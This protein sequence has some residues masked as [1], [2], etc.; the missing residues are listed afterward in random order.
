MTWAEGEPRATG[1]RPA[2]RTNQGLSK[3]ILCSSTNAIRR[4][5]RPGVYAGLGVHVRPKGA[6]VRT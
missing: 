5:V 6:C 1:K 4:H 2:L 3:E